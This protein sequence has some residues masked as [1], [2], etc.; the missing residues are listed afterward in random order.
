MN[1]PNTQ[2]FA[3][4]HLIMSSILL[5]Y[6]IGDRWD[7]VMLLLA[8]M[9]TVWSICII[10]HAYRY[11]HDR[12]WPQKSVYWLIAI[13]FLLLAVLFAIP[14]WPKSYSP[15]WIV[16]WLVLLYA[17][18]M[19]LYQSIA[20]CLS[21]ILPICAYY[22]FQEGTLWTFETL[23][24]VLGIAM[25]IIMVA[26]NSERLF[27]ASYFDALTQLP[28]RQ[29]FMDTLSKCQINR[30]STCRTAVL[31][32]DLDGFKHVNDTMGH[33]VG[34]EV[35]R[36]A[37]KRLLSILP[38]QATLFRMGGDEFAILLNGMKEA[39]EAA[40]LAET[41]TK[42]FQT[43]FEIGK[44][45]IYLSASI[46]I[47]L[48]PDDGQ[49]ANTLLR[50]ADTAMYEVKDKGRNH[51][52]FYVP[53]HSSERLERV[54]ME[55]MLRRA[56]ERDELLVYY[57]PRLDTSSQELVCVEALVRWNHPEKGFILPGEFIQLA[58]EKGLVVGIGEQVLRKAC[59]QR[60]RWTDAGF[61]PFRVSVNLS[62]QQFMHTDLPN[63]IQSILDQTGLP[64][65]M[66]ELELTESAAMKDV[67]YARLMFQKFKEMGLT[68]A[69][70]DFGTGYSSLS[71][72]KKFPIDIL[73]IDQS[74]THGIHKNPDDVAIIRAIIAMGHSLKLKITA[75]GVETIEQL[76]FLRQLG[77][78]EYQGY[79]IGKPMN[80][81]A[82]EDWIL[83]HYG[84]II[85]P[86]H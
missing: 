77:C 17:Y 14:E 68:L 66:L 57:Q 50:N 11:K 59:E 54:E 38:K 10:L 40:Q 29:L 83:Y 16:L 76:D 80:A 18:E 49:D 4:G 3:Y 19:N 35:L 69:I 32:L 75:E 71:Y 23:M 36:A 81:K 85:Q 86:N 60:K 46:G 27:R 47:T 33:D 44:H 24:Y 28:N 22:H 8:G 2:M 61:P 65:G 1:Q 45:E 58:E 41:I 82:M 21:G 79:L 6:A 70:D 52:Q 25:I 43:P 48:A 67:N 34:D 84:S 64:P 13:D 15:T 12:D 55:A 42:Q 20:A 7:P 5:L 53:I 78:D 51:Y 31:L 56:L 74:F 39:E 30:R 72:L 26:R 37:T 9:F 73:K 62:A 63:K